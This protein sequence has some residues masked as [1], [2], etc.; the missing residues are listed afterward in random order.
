MERET[1]GEMK[2]LYFEPREN[3]IEQIFCLI[4]SLFWLTIE[5]I[6]KK[7]NFLVHFY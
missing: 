7:C 2:F 1:N 5:K 3:G 4:K 6:I